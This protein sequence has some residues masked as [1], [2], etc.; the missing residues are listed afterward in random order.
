MATVE[1]KQTKNDDKIRLLK[2]QNAG[3]ISKTELASS[4][5]KWKAAI[6]VEHATCELEHRG[7]GDGDCVEHARC[8]LEHS[9]VEHAECELEHRSPTET[10]LAVEDPILTFPSG[11]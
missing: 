9:G 2:G 1:G 7:T 3:S 6:G 5:K 8:E 4:G 10:E 11:W